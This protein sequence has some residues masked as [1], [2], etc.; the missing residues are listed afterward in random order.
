[1]AERLDEFPVPS[2]AVAAERARRLRSEYPDASLDRLAA[3]LGVAR[4]TL[5]RRLM[6]GGPE[7]R[8]AERETR[9][10]WTV[11]AVT[12]A[13]LAWEDRHGELPSAMDWS[14][15]QIRRKG[16]SNADD[17]IAR[18][19][20]PWIDGRGQEQRFP[21]AGVVPFRIALQAIER[22]RSGPAEP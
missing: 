9:L 18:W 12:R 5:S 7:D 13:L 19:R 10:K 16:H 20:A 15:E 14:P 17:R 11:E 8:S 3:D 4:K 21:R 2:P 6:R 1:M 22:A